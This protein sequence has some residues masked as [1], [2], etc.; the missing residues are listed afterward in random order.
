M[1][2][3]E[4]GFGGAVGGEVGGAEFAEHGGGG[5]YVGACWGGEEGGE[6]G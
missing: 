2:G 1:Q 4:A 6:E 3:D 5:D